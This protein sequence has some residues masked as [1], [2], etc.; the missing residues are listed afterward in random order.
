MQ[1]IF[2]CIYVLYNL[3]R[4]RESS[5]E[6]ELRLEKEDIVKKQQASEDKRKKLASKASAFGEVKTVKKPHQ[7]LEKSISKL[8]IKKI[9]SKGSGLQT[10]TSTSSTTSP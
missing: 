9:K 1:C 7:E 10:Q 2:P 8:R 3:L 4:F 6:T 5:F